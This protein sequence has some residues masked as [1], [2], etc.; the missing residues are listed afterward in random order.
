M[1]ARA[2]RDV[3][4]ELPV[5]IDQLVDTFA[6]AL[7]TG[8]ADFTFAPRP[9]A[10]AIRDDAVRVEV[11]MRY[12]NQPWATTDVDLAPAQAGDCADLSR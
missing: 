2:T 1:R 10:Q 9:R 8:Y 4:V 5:P 11:A 3:D 7:E 12:L 6:A